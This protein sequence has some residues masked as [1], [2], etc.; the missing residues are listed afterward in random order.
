MMM[1]ISSGVSREAT[2]SCARRP[3]PGIGKDRLDDDA[4]AEH[5]ADCRPSTVTSGSSALRATCAST[6]RRRDKPARLGGEH[7]IEPPR[8]G[9]RRAHRA[10]IERE[11]DEAEGG[12]RQDQVASDVGRARQ[13]GLARC[14]GLDPARAAANAARWRRSRSAPGPARSRARHKAPA[15]R[16]TARDRG[17][18]PGLAPA[19]MPSNEPSPNDSAVALPIRSSVLGSRSAITAPIGREKVTDQPRSKWASDQR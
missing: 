4:A 18:C 1:P 2:A 8:L 16:S 14:D 6:M 3:R 17:S 9:H 11:I 10:Q 7:E 5:R 12:D 13:P 19:T 15:S